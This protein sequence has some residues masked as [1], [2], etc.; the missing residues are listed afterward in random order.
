MAKLLHFLEGLHGSLVRTVTTKNEVLRYA[1]LLENLR[2]FS[3]RGVA[4]V[5]DEHCAT[6]KMNVL[7]NSLCQGHPIVWLHHPLVS[8]SA[9]IHVGHTIL[10]QHHHDL[11]N[12]GV[13]SWAETT[14]SDNDRSAR[15]WIEVQHLSRS[16]LQHLEV[17]V[18][19]VVPIVELVDCLHA[20]CLITQHGFA[21]LSQGICNLCRLEGGA[22]VHKLQ[23]SDL[24][25][26]LEYTVH[27]DSSREASAEL[28]R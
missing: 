12:D 7:N 14:A 16:C 25:A 15:L 8:T 28:S 19:R 26:N 21:C 18:A 5:T 17:I 10:L 4:S 27:T 6:L 24:I 22:Q 1:P 2:N 13:Q 23:P 11:P 3:M 9:S 20:P